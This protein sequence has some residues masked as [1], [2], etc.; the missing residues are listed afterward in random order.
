MTSKKEKYSHSRLECF[1]QCPLRYKFRYIEKIKVE[2]KS[3]EGFLGSKVH[4]TLEWLYHQVKKEKIPTIDEM[5]IH[6]ATNWEKDFNS[7]IYF[8]VK[9]DAKFH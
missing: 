2:K 9:K 5:I 8:I 6:Y 3:I 7:E 4:E 1:K